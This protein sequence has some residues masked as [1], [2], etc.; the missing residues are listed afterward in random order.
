MSKPH[1]WDA[2]DPEAQHQMGIELLRDIRGQYILGQALAIA[3]DKLAKESYPETSNIE[4]MEIL[5]EMIFPMGYQ[6]TKQV[7]TTL[8]DDR[9]GG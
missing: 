9:H 2:L 4:D 7:T 3:T 8:S 6:L 1:D 5:G